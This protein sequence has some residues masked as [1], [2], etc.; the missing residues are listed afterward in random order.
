MNSSGTICRSGRS[1]KV[2]NH[3]RREYILYIRQPGKYVFGKC[4]IVWMKPVEST[5]SMLLLLAYWR[6]YAILYYCIRSLLLVYLYYLYVGEFDEMEFF[7][8]YNSFKSNQTFPYITIYIVYIIM[9]MLCGL[10]A[11]F[12]HRV[13]GKRFY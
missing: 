8:A 1:R 7:F 11:Y 2:V 9:F 5:P 3:A 12:H 6:I 10:C 13:L 4:P